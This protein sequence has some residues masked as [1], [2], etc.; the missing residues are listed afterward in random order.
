MIKKGEYDLWSMKMRQYIA[1][2]IIYYG[3]IIT[4]GDQA[5]TDPASSSG[6]VFH[7]AEDAKT[8]WSA[9]KARFGGKCR[10]AIY[11]KTEQMV[12]RKGRLLAIEDSIQKPWWQLNNNEDIDWTKEFDADPVTFAL[13]ALTEIKVDDWSMEFD[14][15]LDLYFGQMDG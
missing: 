10:F 6:P 1:S 9:I 3:T 8:L 11:Q 15:N 14:E 2:L 7:D 4:N 12:L 13:M 5:T